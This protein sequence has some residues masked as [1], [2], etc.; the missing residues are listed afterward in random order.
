M[1]VSEDHELGAADFHLISE[2]VLGGGG[3]VAGDNMDCVS[4]RVAGS[5][6]GGIT[7]CMAHSLR[8]G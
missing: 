2:G 5:T 4:V 6:F 8:K 3:R 7:K 1:G